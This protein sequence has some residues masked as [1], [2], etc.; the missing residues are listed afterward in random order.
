MTFL[1]NS[2]FSALETLRRDITGAVLVSGDDAFSAAV[3]GHNLAYAHRPSVAVLAAGPGDVARA[4]KVAAA[5]RLPVH[6][7]ATGHGA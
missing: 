1:T 7:Q 2:T 3:R 4:V 6:L 5:H